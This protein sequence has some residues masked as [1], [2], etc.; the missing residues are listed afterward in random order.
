MNWSECPVVEVVPGRLSG[1]PVIRNSRVRPEDLIGNLPETPEWLADAFGLP[2]PD[3]LE[4]LAF[5]KMHQDRLAHT[6]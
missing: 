2:L 5:Y 3:V 6:A 1:A 4:V